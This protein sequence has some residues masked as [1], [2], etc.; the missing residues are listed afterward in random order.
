MTSV[1]QGKLSLLVS[2]DDEV[3]ANGPFSVDVTGTP[4]DGE[5]INAT[6][7]VSPGE[8][9]DLN[10]GPGSYTFV[11]AGRT[12]EETVYA[13]AES[14]VEFDGAHDQTVSLVVQVDDEATKA[15][16]DQRAAEEATRA[17]AEAEAQARAQ[18][19]AEAQARAQAEAERQRA[20]AAA[21][22]QTNERTVYITR[23]GEKYHESWCSSLRKS[24]IPISLSEAEAQG[25]E[26]C[27]NCH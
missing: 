4:D 21:P 24:K 23:T 5:K 3:A 10:Y 16:A 6:I 9:L 11:I 27:K 14:T 12:V 1:E 7:T 20:E 18:A 13:Q 17:Q 26:P 8:P 22:S 15:L 2:A 19:E 25:Y